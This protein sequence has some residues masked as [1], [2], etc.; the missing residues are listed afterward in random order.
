MIL[1]AKSAESE[2]RKGEEGES[3]GGEQEVEERGL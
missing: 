3:M 1:V 2:D